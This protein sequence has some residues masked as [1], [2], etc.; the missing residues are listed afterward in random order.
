MACLDI[1]ALHPSVGHAVLAPSL[2]TR[3][4]HGL[5]TAQA[6]S[7]LLHSHPRAAP[8]PC[9]PSPDRCS[10][11]PGSGDDLSPAS[12]QPWVRRSLVKENDMTLDNQLRCAGEMRRRKIGRAHV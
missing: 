7:V 9:R 5:S 1:Y 11:S 4:A 6:T 2:G 3:P 8:I 10:E 12:W